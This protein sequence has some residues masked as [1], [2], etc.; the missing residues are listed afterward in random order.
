[1]DITTTEHRDQYELEAR[2]RSQQGQGT[3]RLGV[4]TIGGTMDPSI[5]RDMKRP[6]GDGLSIRSDSIPD[7]DTSSQKRSDSLGGE[8][9]RVDVDVSGMG[10]LPAT[11]R[12][13]QNS[14]V[15]PSSAYPG[16]NYRGG[17]A[18]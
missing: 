1:M 10:N 7:E 14:N 9:V 4:V 11:R 18:I 12:H 16:S 8:E 13:Y 15:P 2:Y 17:N 6:T 3:S 5:P